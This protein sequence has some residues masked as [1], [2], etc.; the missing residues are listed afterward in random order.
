MK[1]ICAISLFTIVTLAASTGLVA[2]EPTVKANI[3]FN[4]TVGN[5]SMPAGEY[6]ISAPDQNIVKIQSADRQHM[7]LVTAIHSSHEPA[8]GA[9]LVFDKCGDYYFLHRILSSRST[10]LNLDV[11][12]GKVEKRVRTRE[13]KLETGE[14]TLV[15]AR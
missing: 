3:P 4:F 9:Q 7:E 6:T 8:A 12:L 5:R 1:R 11:A 13:A 14:Q 15:A 2:Q 10:S